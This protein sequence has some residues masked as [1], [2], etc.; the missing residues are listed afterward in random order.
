MLPL[1]KIRERLRPT[2][3]YV[4][5][6]GTHMDSRTRKDLDLAIL[7]VCIGAL[8]PVITGFPGASPI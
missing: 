3:D 7:A 6:Y 1:L 4:A 8:F 2:S 5:G